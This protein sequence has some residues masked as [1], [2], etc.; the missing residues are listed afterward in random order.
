MVVAGQGIVMVLCSAV[1]QPWGGL[2]AS[3][4]VQGASLLLGGLCAEGAPSTAPR[5]SLAV[6][7]QP[8]RS[9][10]PSMPVGQGESKGLFLGN[11]DIRDE[12]ERE[13]GQWRFINGHREALAKQGSPCCKGCAQ[14]LPAASHCPKKSPGHTVRRKM[15][16]G[17]K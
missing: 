1:L 13:Q 12:K 5:I 15:R 7:A 11:I 6:P 16:V 9:A 4:S 17:Q 10:V 8:S 3:L 14:P 2:G